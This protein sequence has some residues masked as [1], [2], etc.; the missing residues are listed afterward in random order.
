MPISYKQS[1]VNYAPMDFLKRLAQK[2]GAKTAKNISAAGVEVSSSRGESAHVIEFKDYYLASVIEGLGTKSLVADEMYK[3]T[4][5]TYYDSLAQDTVAMIVNDLIT[6]G[7]KPINILAYWATGDSSW[8]EDKKRV[9]DLVSGWKKACDISGASWGGGETPTLTGVINKKT[10]DLAGASYGTITPKSRLT[11][12]EKIKPG[13]KIVLFESSGIHANGLS[14]ARKIADSLPKGYMTKI[15][16]GMTF[17]EALLEPTLIYSSLIQDIF[18][19]GV[20]IKYMVNVTGH[21]WRKLMRARQSFTYRFHDIPPVPSVLQFMMEKGPISEKEAYG[22][23]NMGAGFAIFVTASHVDK[24]ISIAKKN[25]IRVYP[26]GTV[27]KGKKQVIIEPKKIVFS[28]ST[29]QV[30]A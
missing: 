16:G 25:K 5:K 28:S 1:G 26:Y 23:L 2:E 29:L 13:D 4:G 30:R 7:A 11:L 8:F 6:V 22:N 10:I 19:E 24:V 3:A 21:G 18:N 17:G 27:E 20:D 15:S 14:L 9:K 12:G